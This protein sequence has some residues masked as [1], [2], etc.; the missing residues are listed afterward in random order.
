MITLTPEVAALTATLRQTR[1]TPALLFYAVCELSPADWRRAA[2]ISGR[3]P[4]DPSTKDEVLRVL[5]ADGILYHAKIALRT[6][7]V[8]TINDAIHR[9]LLAMM[10]FANEAGRRVLLTARDEIA[11][12]MAQKM[13]RA[14]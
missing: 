6:R 14:A 7:E 12:H 3:R 1:P 2:V 13:A 11:A 10:V 9:G 4:P 8:G 5:A